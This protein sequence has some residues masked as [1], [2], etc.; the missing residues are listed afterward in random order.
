[1]TVNEVIPDHGTAQRARDGR[2]L[3]VLIADDSLITHTIGK[4]ILRKAGCTSEC[5]DNGLDA[6]VAVRDVCA[7]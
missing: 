2:T 5:V 3:H 1:M 6:V 4:A 7:Y